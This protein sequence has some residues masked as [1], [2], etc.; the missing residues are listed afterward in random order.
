MTLG[1]PI[2]RRTLGLACLFA[3]CAACA[4]TLV[5]SDDPDMFHHLALGREIV[6]SGLFTDERFTFPSL[7][8]PAGVA[9]YWLGSVL[10]YLWHAL[11]GDAGLSLLPAALGA[12]LCVVLIIDA[13]PRGERHS[14]LTLA[15]AALPVALALETFRYRAVP[16][17]EVFGAVLLAWTMWAIRRFE[18]GRRLPLL[19]FPAVAILWTNLH[20]SIAIAFVPLS[21]LVLATAARA[22]L[23]R[24]RSAADAARRSWRPA[25]IAAAVLGTGI[26]ATALRPGFAS[27]LSIAIRFALTTLG[28]GETVAAGHP[29]ILNVARTVLEMQGGGAALFTSPVGALIA[30]SA[31][32]FAAR[33]RSLRARELLTVAAFAVL[34]FAAVR[35]ALFFAVV[36]APIAA[37]NFGAALAALPPRVGRVPTRSLATAAC[38]AAA[39]ASLPLGALAPHIRFGSGVAYEAFP[40]RAA[41]YLEAAGFQ[42]RLF[43]TFHLGGFLEWRRVGPPYQDGRG[44]APPEDAPGATAGPLD[45]AAF[46]PLDERYRFDALVLAYPAVDPD[47][48]RFVGPSAFS[49]DPERW[50]LVAFDD[51]G[52]LY[53]R[54]DGRYAELAARDEFKVASPANL[55]LLSAQPPA[56]PTLLA[57]LRRAVVE[58][59]RCVRCRY[60]EAELALASGLPREAA[61]TAAEAIPLAYGPARAALESVAG[62]AG[63]ALA[64]ERPLP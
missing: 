25:A 62:R 35:F 11:L 22:A 49:P 44:G 19:L 31:L 47:V 6:R 39:L 38:V 21:L 30:L 54:R 53:L 36:A 42:G 4:A 60:L 63:L 8:Q 33:W 15:A 1:E 3:A 41:D 10:I 2:P 17:P 61:A 28:L 9:L 43:N 48:A 57:E 16:R 40:V 58:A 45:R 24:S 5:G 56:F 23:A 7:G 13:A 51:G 55:F 64:G 50:A 20:P 14:P 59:P 18:E 52:L 27:T 34:P 37:R 32:S 29:S 46:A 26:L 12:L